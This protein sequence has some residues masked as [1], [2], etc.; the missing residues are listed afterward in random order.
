MSPGQPQVEEKDNVESDNDSK[1]GDDL[2]EEVDD[3]M[4]S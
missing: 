4:N 1:D 3:L 2:T